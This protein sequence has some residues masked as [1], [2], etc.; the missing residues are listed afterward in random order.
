MDG[1]SLVVGGVIVLAVVLTALLLD[2]FL[3]REDLDGAEMYVLLMLSAAGGLVMAGAT[4]LIV[5]FLGLETLSIAVYVMAAMH[6]H[7]SRVARIRPQV[8][9]PAAF[10]S[11]FLLLRDRA[12]LRSH[13]FVEP[14]RDPDLPRR[15]GDPRRRHAAGR[16]RLPPRR[17]RL[18]EIA[19]VPF[20]AWTPDVYQGRPDPGV[21]V[22]GLRGQSS[23]VRRSSGCSRSP[24][25]PS[26]TTGS[27]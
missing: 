11:A 26:P 10:S 5:L 22:H 4:D 16:V 12:R 24:S 13:R 25:C 9:R 14:R 7:R 20:H 15:G 2:Q 1:F 21:G 3:R 6:A 23:R 18:Q 19:A 27:R 8:L 17:L